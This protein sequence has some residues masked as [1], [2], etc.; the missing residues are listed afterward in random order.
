MFILAVPQLHTDNKRPMQGKLFIEPF[1]C[2]F[3]V[4]ETLIWTAIWKKP[5]SSAHFPKRTGCTPWFFKMS[6]GTKLNCTFNN[7]RLNSKKIK[8]KKMEILPF[9]MA[10]FRREDLDYK[11]S[12]MAAERGK[13]K[14]A[15]DARF[16]STG[17][18][19]D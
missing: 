17:A 10:T 14:F 1:V 6:A 7:S 4:E 12:L 5:G 8:N 19:L 2:I 13:W 16:S 3:M 18:P 9:S 11:C 15:S